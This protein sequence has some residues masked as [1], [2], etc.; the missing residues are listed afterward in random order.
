MTCDDCQ[1]LLPMY[2]LGALDES[3]A[4]QVRVHLH[5][6]CANCAAHL[7]ATQSVLEILPLSLAPV[8]PPPALRSRLM[9]RVAGTSDPGAD[10]RHVLSPV[11]RPPGFGRVLEALIAGTAAAAVTAAVFWY[12][13][14]QQR[15]SVAV[16]RR[17]LDE[18]RAAIQKL[19][20]SVA[21][22]NDSIQLLKSPSVQ[23]VSLEGTAEQPRAKARVYWDQVRGEWHFYASNLKPLDDARAYE[24]W[25]IDA[26]QRKTP[27][28]TFKV[29]Q[30][31]EATLVAQA[32]PPPTPVVAFAVTDE[33]VGGTSQ[34]TGRIQLVGQVK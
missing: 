17:E 19:Q 20:T 3:E 6:G 23:L 21:Q 2:A 10:E 7:A 28:G 30:G 13:S 15:K 25:L 26:G 24:L 11:V 34:P 32:P 22:A 27:A 33:P 16:L 5:S 9:N 14:S 12:S 4:E 8:G 31:G 29:S 18:A 1:N